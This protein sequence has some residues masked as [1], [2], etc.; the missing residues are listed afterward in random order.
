MGGSGFLT[1]EEEQKFNG[2]KIQVRANT[3]KTKNSDLENVP[4]TITKFKMK[5]Y[6][7][8]LYK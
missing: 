8:E 3:M 1:F 5:H 4:M 6:F 7:Y 2:F